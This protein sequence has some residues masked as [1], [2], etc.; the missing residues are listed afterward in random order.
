[1]ER[2]SKDLS[3]GIL[4]AYKH[5]KLQSQI[6][7]QICCQDE[8]RRDWRGHTDRDAIRLV[9]TMGTLGSFRDPLIH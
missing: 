5:I 3:N 9:Y 8:T 2:S 7:K 1:M 4:H 6:E